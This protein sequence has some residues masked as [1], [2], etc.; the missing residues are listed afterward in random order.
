M[1][2]L[3]TDKKIIILSPNLRG[4]TKIFTDYEI[5]KLGKND[6]GNFIIENKN[7]N[8]GHFDYLTSPEF[9]QS[10]TIIAQSKNH[11]RIFWSKAIYLS[12]NFY[13]ISRLKIAENKTKWGELNSE[14]KRNKYYY[15]WEIRS[16]KSKFNKSLLL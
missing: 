7:I 15:K 11:D 10:I 1:S 12:N 8:N 6:S 16:H 3:L 14:N 4:A 2:W 13:V 9:L 5:L